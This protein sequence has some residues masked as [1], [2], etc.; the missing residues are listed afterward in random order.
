MKTLTNFNKQLTEKEAEEIMT[1][2]G[3]TMFPNTD[4]NK[5]M[6]AKY[7]D[8]SLKKLQGKS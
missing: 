2:H 8:N 7:L 4:H 5:K 6:T 3:P 1:Y